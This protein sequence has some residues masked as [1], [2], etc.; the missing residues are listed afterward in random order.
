M[1]TKDMYIP[2]AST[3]FLTKQMYFR[4]PGPNDTYFGTIK[5][6]IKGKIVM[7]N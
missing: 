2:E 3:F 1:T 7:F 6:E 5:G 4:N